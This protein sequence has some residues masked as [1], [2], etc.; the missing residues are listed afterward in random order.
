MRFSSNKGFTVSIGA[1]LIIYIFSSIYFNEKI[2]VFKSDPLRYY[3][4]LPALIIHHDISLSFTEKPENEYLKENFILDK[5]PIDKLYTKTT[6]GLAILYLP[7]FTLGHIYALATDYMADGYSLPYQ[8]FLRI[9]AIIYL[10]IG[11]FYLSQVLSKFISR[12]IANL[13]I[14]AI[15]LGTNLFHYT[16]FEG[17]VSHVYSFFLITLFLWLSIKWHEKPGYKTSVLLGF[18][19]GLII[20]IRP[21]DIIILIFFILFGVTSFKETSNRIGLFID[22]YKMIILMGLITFL[23]WVPQFLYWKYISGHFIFNSYPDSRFFFNNPQIINQLFSYR[24]GWLLYTPMMVLSIF[25]LL[26]IYKKSFRGVLL[27]I[28]LFTIIN[29]YILSSWYSWWFGGG[30]G[31]R[32]YIN[33]YPLMAIPLGVLIQFL[34]KSKMVIKI[35]GVVVI[36]FISILNIT[37]TYQYTYGYLHWIAMTKEAYWEQFLRFNYSD[38]YRNYL[39][40][41]NY[42]N[43]YK[44]IYDPEHDYTWDEFQIIDSESM[45]QK[46]MNE[47][48]N[49]E[50]YM[51]FIREKARNNGLTIDEQ[52]RL[53]AKWI[54]INDIEMAKRQKKEGSKD[55]K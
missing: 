9:G 3:V 8:I 38:K 21:T 30:F 5:S 29:I 47:I 20:L 18:V 7:F 54:I 34:L 44:G 55:I 42:G 48:R 6:Y 51:D 12:L 24:K 17:A 41:P 33:S 27:P 39:L 50:K 26:F 36:S 40:F 2:Y 19:F 52:L 4:Y 31:S 46:K 49:S 11:M 45:V 28:S 23:V 1:I 37:Q 10:L 53:D 35:S 25:G 16:V 13:T 22:N 43:A 15:S 14:I 32:A